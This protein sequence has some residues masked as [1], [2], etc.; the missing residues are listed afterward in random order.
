MTDPDYKNGPISVEITNWA[1][2]VK[3]PYVKRTTLRTYIMGVDGDP[4]QICDY[5]PKRFRMTID[6]IDSDVILTLNTPV[7]SPDV[8]T[9]AI[10]PEGAHL[11][12]SNSMPYEFNGPD[13]FWLNSVSA[14]ATTRVVVVKEYC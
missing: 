3:P 7:A 1:D 2:P 12:A 9:A 5:E 10:A 4:V 8:S 13:A 14:G 11:L 6:P